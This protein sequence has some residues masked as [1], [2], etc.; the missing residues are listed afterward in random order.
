MRTVT[1]V[2]LVVASCLATQAAELNRQKREVG[3]TITRSLPRPPGGT[4]GGA[5]TNGSHAQ[6]QPG[7]PGAPGS[8]HQKPTMDSM[9]M[10]GKDDD[11]DC[12]PP[13]TGREWVCRIDHWDPD[14]EMVVR[15][16]KKQDCYKDD[17][18]ILGPLISYPLKGPWEK[19][20][21]CGPKPCK[22]KLASGETK[23]YGCHDP[24]ATCEIG[25]Y[26]VVMNGTKH[27]AH[28]C[29]PHPVSE[30]RWVPQLCSVNSS[31]T[32]FKKLKE[33]DGGETCGRG[34]V[35]FW[36]NATQ[37]RAYL[38]TK[39][40]QPRE[41]Y[42]M[43]S[44]E[45]KLIHKMKMQL[46]NMA[47]KLIM[48]GYVMHGGADPTSPMDYIGQVKVKL[49]LLRGHIINY[50]SMK[51]DYQMRGDMDHMAMPGPTQKVF[52]EIKEAMFSLKAKIATLP[53]ND[54]VNEYMDAGYD[55]M[56]KL[57]ERITG[58][59]ADMKPVELLKELKDAVKYLE[60]KMSGAEMKSE[61]TKQAFMKMHILAKKVYKQA[62]EKAEK[63][64]PKMKMWERATKSMQMLWNFISDS[65]AK[66]PMS[67]K[68]VI[69]MLHTTI[70]QLHMKMSMPKST[71]CEELDELLSMGKEGIKKLSNLV[72]DGKMK[73]EETKMMYGKIHKKMM[74]AKEIMKQKG[75]NIEPLEMMGKA[76]MKLWNFMSDGP[77]PDQY[78]VDDVLNKI[79]ESLEHA[80]KKSESEKDKTPDMMK[81][82]EH[83]MKKMMGEGNNKAKMILK[84]LSGWAQGEKSDPLMELH[85]IFMKLKDYYLMMGELPV[86][87]EELIMKAAKILH[88]MTQ[89]WADKP[90]PPPARM[91]V[92]AITKV[93]HKLL[94]SDRNTPNLAM[95]FKSLGEP[96]EELKKLAQ[97]KMKKDDD[98]KMQNLI[99]MNEA[100]EE[101]L[102]A[103]VGGLRSDRAKTALSKVKTQMFILQSTFEDYLEDMPYLLKDI[104]QS[105]KKMKKLWD[106]VWDKEKDG[107]GA[108]LLEDAMNALKRVGGALI[109][110]AKKPDSSGG[111]DSSRRSPP[112]SP[113]SRMAESMPRPSGGMG[114][115]GMMGGMGGYDGKMEDKMMGGGRQGG[116]DDDDNDDD[117]ND[118]KGYGRDNDKKKSGPKA[119]LEMARKTLRYLS[120]KAMESK[121]RSEEAKKL[122][123]KL[124]HTMRNV[125][126]K[127][128]EMMYG[129][130][131]ERV[132]KAMGNVQRHMMMLWA[133]ITGS[134]AKPMMHPEQIISGLMKTV[135]DMHS[136]MQED[137]DGMWKWGQGM[138]GGKKDGYGDDYGNMDGGDYDK[139]KRG[140]DMGKYDDDSMAMGKY[141]P[142]KQLR[143][144]YS[145]MSKVSS[146][147]PKDKAS[148][149]NDMKKMIGSMANG[150]YNNKDDCPEE[151]FWM[152]MMPESEKDKW[153]AH[154]SGFWGVDYKKW[155]KKNE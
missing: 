151:D 101:L 56:K 128:M 22:V 125:K 110:L 5:G 30:P 23:D 46:E 122:F 141:N 88:G 114:D 92:G 127:A 27:E 108:D 77:I 152:D 81:E 134:P 69:S 71:D 93:M 147:M 82:L 9:E 84:E 136:K 7:R 20:W 103:S 55:A 63:D 79:K 6:I 102:F 4:H 145:M 53:E 130:G 85:N 132:E 95:L 140:T 96:F 67:P 32:H 40:P 118:D 87:P 33:C 137:R 51:M 15:S 78:S 8:H 126:R 18:C 60:E 146:N 29:A 49:P 17:M 34:P 133:H 116:Y 75:K 154:Q 64:D 97:Y 57:Y 129:S 124:S 150:M 109:G 25:P 106:F 121:L 35:H 61:E 58:E 1:I 12:G 13:R 138:G 73:E 3:G 37:F 83:K 38:C 104:E 44:P 21:M 24:M 91:A 98:K 72:R 76:M 10:R 59:M 43:M 31:R 111:Y 66:P 144:I 39:T 54:K 153:T 135:M 94:T 19:K 107:N 14:K 142:S 50:M 120:N 86:E 143:E 99:K 100:I 36:H 105:G 28:F 131:M 117:Y 68:E 2:T 65:P 74:R 90:V 123:E 47:E 149:L 113:R 52:N 26:K 80:E 70:D 41:D 48:K 148:K 42:N 11:E 119:M 89:K 16:I 115:Y 62:I 155:G 45:D 139:G 112:P